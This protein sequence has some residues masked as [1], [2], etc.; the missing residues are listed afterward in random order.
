M[1][2]I[3]TKGLSKQHE[4]ILGYILFVLN[5]SF[6]LLYSNLRNIIVNKRVVKYVQRT[7]PL[8]FSQEQFEIA[9]E[10]KDC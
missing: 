4:R 6:S 3:K 7:N 8:Q 5:L 10:R 2:K 9:T 1:S